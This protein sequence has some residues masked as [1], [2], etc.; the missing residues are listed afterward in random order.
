MKPK[1]NLLVLFLLLLAA[2]CN[3]SSHSNNKPENDI[4]AARDFIRAALDGK[5]DLAKTYM[6]EDSSN[7]QYLDAVARNYQK[8]DDSTREEYREASINIHKVEPLNDSTTIIIF[9]NSFKND[10]D[11]LQV[12]KVN[13][14]WVVNLKYIF[15]H[16]TDSSNIK[17]NRIDTIQ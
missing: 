12:L 6:L 11:T 16:G 5:F 15:N 10:K 1:Y 13:Q 2:S 14:Q 8:Y 7:V 3:N 9:S 4:D 17:L